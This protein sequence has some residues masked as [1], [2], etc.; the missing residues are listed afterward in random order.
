MA[1]DGFDLVD[2]FLQSCFN[3]FDPKDGSLPFFFASEI[4]MTEETAFEIVCIS[5]IIQV[6]ILCIN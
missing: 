1:I 2:C 4:L 3:V 5:L 6:E